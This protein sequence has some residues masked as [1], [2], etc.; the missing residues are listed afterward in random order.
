[1]PG[2]QIVVEKFCVASDDREQIVEVVGDTPGEL[3]ERF[4][5]LCLPQLLFR[6]A[7]GSDV[8]HH[9]LEQRLFGRVA[10]HFA[11]DPYRDCR[12]VRSQPV[13]FVLTDLCVLDPFRHQA[14]P[15]RRIE[16]ERVRAD[17]DQML[18]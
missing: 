6:P 2:L 16:I 11:S 5:L 18:G 1:M 12:S 4:H 8:L 15:H 13:D 7:F 10:D 14:G 3:P 17:F 9:H